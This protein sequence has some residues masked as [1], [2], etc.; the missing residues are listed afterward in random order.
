MSHQWMYI[1]GFQ[2]LCAS[3]NIFFFVLGP[4]S[5]TDF[6]NRIEGH[7]LSASGEQIGSHTIGTFDQV[8][9]AIYNFSYDRCVVNHTEIYS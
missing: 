3:P 7:R 6:V 8:N 4:V 1:T 9:S 5:T 2:F